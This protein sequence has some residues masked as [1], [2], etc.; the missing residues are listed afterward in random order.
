M[1]GYY[2]DLSSAQEAALAEF[3]AQVDPLPDKPFD[4]DYFY[5]RQL[6]ARKFNVKKAVAMLK[7]VC[8]F[9]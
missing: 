8:V 1:S 9:L 6:R 3:K 7:N 2:S 4:D 5:L